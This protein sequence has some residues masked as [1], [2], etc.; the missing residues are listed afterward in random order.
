[1]P[2]AGFVPDSATGIDAWINEG[3]QILH[4]KLV[5][6]YGEDYLESSAAFTTVAGQTDY[7]LPQD[8]FKLLG[9]DLQVSGKARTLQRFERSERNTLKNTTSAWWN[10][11]RYKIVGSKLRLLPAPIATTGTLFYAPTAPI[12]STG[13]TTSLRFNTHN[14]GFGAQ[15]QVSGSVSGMV[16]G[17]AGTISE[18][19]WSNMD[20]TV[21]LLVLTGVTGTFDINE[22][23]RFGGVLSASTLAAGAQSSAGQTSLDVPNGWERYVV[24]YTAKRMLLKEESD[25][26][27]ID[28]TLRKWDAELEQIKADRDAAFPQQAVDMDMVDVW[29]VW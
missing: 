8:F 29:E 7:D 26:R 2:V 12:L 13:V 23:L 27:E 20:H 11:P 16:S 6:A 1:M 28:A 21:G 24:L 17:A 15:P 3:V 18:I 9:I 25:V 22:S 5:S 10:V 4:E 14:P 19:L